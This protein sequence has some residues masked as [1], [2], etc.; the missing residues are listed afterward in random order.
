M[1]SSYYNEDELKDLG[2]AKLG[3]HVLIS[4]YA[5]IYGAGRMVIGDHVRIDDFCLLSGN[6]TLGNFIH[7][8]V[9]CNLFAGNAGIE[10]RDFSAISSRSAIYAESDDYG[11]DY[12]TNPMVGEDYRHIISGKVTL[13]R[14]VIIGTG[15]TILPDVTLGEGA[16]VGSM[17]LV[18]KSLDPWGIYTGSPCKFMKERSKGVLALEKEFYKTR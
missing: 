5:R 8:A 18:N 10:F 2:F 13:D 6:I 9:G 4:R 12:F 16:A 17:S 14:H 7:I 11:G 1:A 3:E 15:S